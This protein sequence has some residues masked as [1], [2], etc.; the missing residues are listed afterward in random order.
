M[1][2]IL[3]IDSPSTDASGHAALRRRALERLGATV[4]TL[5]LREKQGVLAR[6]RGGGVAD[7][8][9]RAILEQRPDLVLVVDGLELTAPMLAQ[10][11]RNAEATW[12]AWFMGDVRSEPLI[13]AVSGGYDVLFVPGADQAARLVGSSRSPAIYLP[14]AADPSVHRPVKSR[15]EFKSNLVFVGGA[16][17]ER[18]QLLSNVAD[19][20]L[21]VWGPGWKGSPL[22]A[23]C[24]GDALSLEDFVRAYAGAAIGLNVHRVELGGSATGC[25]KRTFELAAIGVA[26]VVDDRADLA[27]HFD[28]GVDLA[29]FRSGAEL[30]TVV[31]ALLQN[32]ARA[33]RMAQAGRRRALAEHTY[34][35]RAST[36]LKETRQTGRRPL[37]T[38]PE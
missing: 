31:Q 6:W 38:T 16:T 1:T 23:Q 7:R 21:A 29:T 15:D 11:R 35:H 24:R 28:V 33:E 27:R 5:D 20:G 9:S 30:R 26:Q 17:P 19:L 10:L 14:P 37:A 4:A 34:M 12:A 25:N 18:E 3:L 32:P 22:K 8:V 2:R 13:E 36:L